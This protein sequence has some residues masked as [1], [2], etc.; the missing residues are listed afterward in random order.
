MSTSGREARLLGITTV[1]AVGVPMGAAA[2]VDA[3][4]TELAD[5]LGAAAE[6]PARIGAI[7]ARLTGTVRVSDVAL[8][9][10]VL[11]DAIEGSVG[12]DSL[13]D[14]E[15]R[16]DEIR[17]ENPIIAIRV[18]SDGDSD[19]ARL[20]R[21][22]AKPAALSVDARRSGRVRRIVVDGGRLT[23]RVAGVGEL[24]A[25]R[26]ELIPDATGARIVTGPVRLR[27]EDRVA[28]DVVFDRSAAELLLPQMRFGRVLAVGG[29][30]TI[31]TGG[32]RVAL[33]GL[34]AGRRL[35]NGV[36][37]VRAV[38]DDAGVPRDVGAD[39]GPAQITLFG[40]RVPL[41]ALAALA[42]PGIDL[43]PTRATGSLTVRRNTSDAAPV[44][45][46]AGAPTG[47]RSLEL[48]LAGSLEHLV[49][50]HRTFASA[51]VTIA[52]KLIGNVVVTGDAIVIARAA[53]QVGAIELTAAGWLR[54]GAPLSGQL[55]VAL[56][57][58]ECAAL[59]GSLPEPLRGPLD[60]MAVTG[61]L[62]AHA[63]LAIDLAAPSAEGATLASRFTGECKVTA[64]P[65]AADVTQ[66]AE[67][68]EQRLNDGSRI[69]VGKGEPEWVS[70]RPLPGHV[71]GAFVS[72]EDGQF[73]EHP[74]F[75]L[76]QIARSL[77]IDLRERRLARGGSTISQ[78]L[79]K[80]AFLTQRRSFDRKL[81]EAILTWRLEARL[82]KHE[83]LERYLNVIELGPRVWGIGRAARYWF[84]VAP[85]DLTVR[86]AAFLA[87]LTSQPASMSRR[88]RKAGGLDPDS[89]ER[90]AIVLR[91]MRRDGVITDEVYLA[92]KTAPLHF[93]KT[94]L[95]D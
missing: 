57:D 15:L 10:L 58:A 40:N 30:G 95:P 44:P 47:P 13:L 63:R 8:G 75:D 69:R 64:E 81:Q 46:V 52:P 37:E 17:V 9:E 33:A 43:G 23:A 78:Q 77:E 65:P 84:D 80:N 91:A 31:D 53:F 56:A 79:V 7:D 73:Y 66:L 35:R 50:D 28:V 6:V 92:A 3:R 67:A 16:A 5:Q 85:R 14:G 54:R 32:E 4:T 60:G 70:L 41:R 55:D 90:V 51:P 45:A 68:S 82:T 71:A 87:A 22:F 61:T 34:A 26:V 27:R 11:A 24:A 59:L 88:V 20:A 48:E 38:V 25:E 76:H 62:G 12:M 1:L 42:P 94:A 72:A 49:L 83:I 19:L 29:S 89:A 36:L 39:I 86:Q 21:R 74:G 18:D 2:W 93:A